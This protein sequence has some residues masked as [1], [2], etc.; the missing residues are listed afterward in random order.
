M[1]D[2]RPI[3]N[4][5]LDKIT[6]IVE[7]N[8]SNEQFGVSELAEA[9]NMSRSNLLRKVKK[10]T[11]L[12]VSQFIREVRLRKAMEILREGN[13]TV[14]EISWQVGFSSTSYFIKC[15][16]E[17]YGYPPGEIREMGDPEIKTEISDE[18]T[19]S[20][21]L[22]AIMFADI[23]GYTAMMQQDEEKALQIRK[24]HREVFNSVTAKFNGKILQY[25]G[26]GT[27]STFH[28]AID[29]VKCGIEIQL[30][31]LEEP[32]VPVRIGIHSG[33]II[34][35]KDGVIGD[36]VNVASRIEA[37]AESRSVFISEKIYDEIKN[38]PGIKTLSLGE[39]HLKNVAK[40]IEVFVVS[41]P[42]LAVPRRE[43]VL[44][45]VEADKKVEGGRG[46]MKVAGTYLAIVLLAIVL[47]VT[48]RPLLYKQKSP[49]KSI[50]VLPFKNDSNDS[51]N[52]Y[53]VNG[54]MESV[55]TNLQK[56]KDLRVISRTS[57]E[58]YRNS[59]KTI[60][61]IAKEL[62]VRYFIEGSG[63]KIGDQ[64]L[65]HIQL[66]E[67]ADDKH[68]WAEQYNRETS[69]I[70]NLQA[71]IAKSIT[72][73]IQVILTPEE[74]ERIAKPPT[75]NLV[76]YDYYLKGLEP[77]NAGTR[78]GLEEAIPFFEKAL[79]Q[80]P[81]FAQAYANLAIAYYFLDIFQAQKKYSGLVN[82]YADKALFY[83]DKLSTAMLAKAFFYMGSGENKLAE[84][85]LQKA[86]EYSPNS[87]FVINTL[88]DFYDS[89]IPNT[90]KYL[91]YALKG[92]QI[93]IAPK[94]SATASYLYL[95][96]SNALIQSGFVDAAEKYIDRSIAYDPTNLFSAYVK[97]Y[98]L[99]AKNK[100]LEA[101]KD[102]LIAVHKRDTTRFD[103]I[104]EIAKVYY[105][106][107]DYPDA[108]QYYKK[109][110]AI[111]TALNL[112]VYRF[113]NAKIGFVLDKVGQKEK[114]GALFEDYF[115]YA[116][117]DQSLYKD[118]SLAMY[119]AH[120]N[121]IEK[122][123]E[124]LQEFSQQDNFHY[125]TIL[126]LNQDPLMDNIKDLPEYK[127]I[128]KEIEKRFWKN[129]REVKA[130]LEAKNLL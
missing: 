5:F 63:Q 20:H 45:K 125:W 130:S 85:Y 103:I 29:A 52:V 36:G 101:L 106:M 15:F 12:S 113:E 124:H 30:A 1:P 107:R 57:V 92:A 89:R 28:S 69:D 118:L 48:L 78:E 115:D 58:K 9:T 120:F 37:L 3:A 18:E 97:P 123:L 108:F 68:L 112:D 99:Y 10:L 119:Y 56:I 104:Q 53:F 23:E 66:I 71:E 102:G 116:K 73:E 17:H 105:Y 50:A 75:D 60:P 109:Y 34:F 129:H 77:F 42:G 14:S 6:G 43:D 117:N 121:Q 40:P 46:L 44:K 65:L 84:P 4:D 61:E 111:K 122:A 72:D 93:D 94:D 86:L 39:F 76:A 79:E 62:N 7:E 27:L 41:N 100:D 67:G 81:E 128:F 24:K 98:I 38:Q 11:E 96:L 55:L 19:Q 91:E 70:F 95:H 13:L 126:F 74:Q 59:S 51:T 47:F 35:S 127:R 21:Q 87:A 114:A 32:Q 82:N 16:R 64:V 80:D 90:K 49:E 26:D 25:Y 31:F 88:S 54:L 83:D 22:A 2:S 33:D 8:I 110:L